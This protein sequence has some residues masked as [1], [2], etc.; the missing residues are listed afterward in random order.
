MDMRKPTESDMC[1]LEHVFFTSVSPWDPMCIDNEAAIVASEDAS[2]VT[3]L[4]EH[5][6]QE[7]IDSLHFEEYVEQCLVYINLHSILEA[8]DDPTI[9]YRGPKSILPKDPDFQALR[10]ILDG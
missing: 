1:A 2:D 3:A 4:L 5:E 8:E 9:L 6:D 10:P 7:A